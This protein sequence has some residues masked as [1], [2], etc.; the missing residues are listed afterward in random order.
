MDGE[1]FFQCRGAIPAVGFKRHDARRY[2][3]IR[4]EQGLGFLLS[5]EFKNEKYRIRAESGL[6]VVSVG[7]RLL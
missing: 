3:R 5:R 7:C 6:G 4:G 1:R 2:G